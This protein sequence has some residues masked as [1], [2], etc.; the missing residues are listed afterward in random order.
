MHTDNT[1]VEKNMKEELNW[2]TKQAEIKKDTS[3]LVNSPLTSRELVAYNN[4][5]S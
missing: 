3:M 2:N 4:D 5:L 1:K